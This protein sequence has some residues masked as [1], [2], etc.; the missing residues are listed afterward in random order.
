MG[1]KTIFKRIRL[2][3]TP[4]LCFFDA[5]NATMPDE[6]YPSFNNG[7]VGWIRGCPPD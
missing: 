6:A 4:Q 1:F 3:N 5:E 7:G 2:I